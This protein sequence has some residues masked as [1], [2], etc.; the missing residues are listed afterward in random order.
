MSTA[1]KRRDSL[2]HSNWRIDS[3]RCQEH[4]TQ[5]IERGTIMHRT[6]SAAF[7]LLFF[8]APTRAADKPLVL[9]LW[10]GK[11][12]DDDAEKIGKEMFRELIVN[13]KPYEVGGK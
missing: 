3:E 5:S 13:G 9:D 1:R 11:P 4:L 7:V 8:I 2:S 12:A 6:L 10:P